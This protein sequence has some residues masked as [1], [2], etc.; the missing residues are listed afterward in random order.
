MRTGGDRERTVHSVSASVPMHIQRMPCT[1]Q[2]DG[3][4]GE[5]RW[6]GALPCWVMIYY[7]VGG[8]A[9]VIRLLPGIRRETKL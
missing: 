1:M 7:M 6:P 9:A 5:T 8:P 4:S 2:S 3:R